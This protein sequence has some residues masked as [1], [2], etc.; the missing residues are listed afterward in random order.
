MGEQG[1]VESAKVDFFIS[2]SKADLAWAEWVTWQLDNEGYRC[3]VQ[4]RDFRPGMD[5]MDRMRSALTRSRQVI[6]L[7][8]SDYMCSEHAQSELNAALRRDPL[9]RGS[10]LLPIRVEK[11]EPQ[12]ILEGRI[13]IDLVGKSPTQAKR[14]LL[15]GVAASRLSF[16]KPAP[17]RFSTKPPFP[18][19]GSEGLRGK[20]DMRKSIVLIS[21]ARSIRTDVVFVAS[22][23]NTGLDLHGQYRKLQAAVKGTLYG[24]KLRFNHVFDATPERLFDAL[25]EH[26]PSIVHISGKQDGG[27]ILMNSESGGVKTIPDAALAGLLRSLSGVKIAIIDTC[28]SLKCAATIAEAVDAALGVQSFIYE[29]DATIFYC[30]FYR[31]FAS[32]RSLRDSV[33]QAS[34]ALQFNRVPWKR[35]PQICT[36]PGVDA[37]NIF[38]VERRS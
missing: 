20:Q 36:R 9:G 13:Y 27:N 35:I 37:K 17:S 29:D 5:F 31:A 30:A 3:L 16:K 33:A 7:L 8:S 15:Q 18:A 4:F 11:C 23:A 34:A 32:G 25:N 24:S 14:D 2:Y 6:A 1:T 22:E 10:L 38:L 12:E 19:E 21:G 28:A 26:N